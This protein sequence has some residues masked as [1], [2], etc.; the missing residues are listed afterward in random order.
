MLLESPE[1]C[2]GH[3]ISEHSFDLYTLLQTIKCKDEYA[4]FKVVNYMRRCQMLCQ[5]F[6]CL[7]SFNSLDTLLD[8]YQKSGHVLEICGEDWKDSR[9]LFPC[10]DNDPLLTLDF[11]DD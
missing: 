10:F 11:D 4:Q 8:H 3:M 1:A 6:S 9:F 7:E 2:K 5:C